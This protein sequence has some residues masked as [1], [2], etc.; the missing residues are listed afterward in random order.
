[1]AEDKDN[2]YVAGKTEK[3]LSPKMSTGEPNTGYSTRNVYNTNG[4]RNGSEYPVTK[5]PRYIKPDPKIIGGART[6]PET[7]PEFQRH[8]ILSAA[9]DHRLGDNRNL[10]SQD[11]VNYDKDGNIVTGQKLQ[12]YNELRRVKKPTEFFINNRLDHFVR[13]VPQGLGG[14]RG[15]PNTEPFADEDVS[16][17]RMRYPNGQTKPKELGV[18]S[19]ATTNVNALNKPEAQ[20]ILDAGTYG[21]YER[22]RVRNGSRTLNP[23][24]SPE[25]P[26]YRMNDD[27]GDNFLADESL[28]N[29]YNRTRLPIADQEWRKG[30]RYLFF[31]RPE[32]YLMYRDGGII[33]VCDQAFYDEDFASAYTR[34]PHIIKMLSPWYVTGSFPVMGSE[35]DALSTGKNGEGMNFNF[36]LSNRVQGL[37]SGGF[38]MTT[39]DSIGKSVEGYTITPAKFVESRQGSSIELSFRDTRNLEVFETARLWMLYMYKRQ[40]GIFLPPYNGYA[41][42]NSFK[43]GGKNI[44]GPLSGAQFTRMHPY[45]RALEYCASLYD[46]VT[47]ESGTK[48]LYWCKYYGIYP[49][50]VNPSLNNDA[51]DAI[52]QME[53]SITFKYHYKLENN[54][55]SL[56]EFNHDAG[57]TDNIGRIN[58]D[59]VTS[60]LPFLLRDGKEKDPNPFLPKYI[61]AAGMFTGSPYVVM[62]ASRPDPL[63]GKILTVPSLRFMNVPKMELDK[64][65]NM[66]IT[67][68]RI[69]QSTRNVISYAS[70][71]SL[72]NA[73]EAVSEAG[74]NI[75]SALTNIL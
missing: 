27:K 68:T 13:D 62:V 72:S 24:I 56:V 3:I 74:R 50:A 37:S 34:M 22:D 58:K 35:Q 51:N 40:K 45:D 10:Y 28:F 26:S 52:T 39:S 4:T 29:A 47:D 36:L 42:E 5:G 6:N 33:D 70:G 75:A 63:S 18:F 67:S 69:D 60:S 65:I 30:F 16:V 20:K 53:T 66:D 21:K 73:R 49:T 31:T 19:G 48:I 2:Q 71:S 15:V 9:M 57:L 59:K 1:M 38:T 17:S 14:E 11:I 55:K 32:C 54:N 25:Y 12:S 7:D 46:I 61:G 43:S 41:K 44:E 64:K 8:L 23:P